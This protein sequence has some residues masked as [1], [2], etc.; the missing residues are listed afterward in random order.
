MVR[1]QLLIRAVVVLFL[2]VLGATV[3]Y[4]SVRRHYASR[5]FAPDASPARPVAIVFGA[6]LRRD[7]TPTSVLEDRVTAAARLYREGRVKK[8]LMSGSASGPY[9]DE[10]GAMR[11]LALG[12]GVSSDDI[13][14][15]RGGNRTFLTC[16]RAVW[17]FGIRE[18]IL[19]SQGF[20][21]PRALAICNALGLEAYGVLADR[22]FY[23]H[24]LESAWNLRE[25]PATLVALW[26]SFVRQPYPGVRRGADGIEG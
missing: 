18:A 26:E 25:I 12:L 4:W 24:R 8:L 17:L 1:F 3:P 19:V 22:R 5:I 7:G 14:I 6:G 2:V 21:L 9:Y 13:L 15:D 10:P 11:E 16:S 20:H 23:G